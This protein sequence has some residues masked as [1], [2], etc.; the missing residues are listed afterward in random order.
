M[1]VG[2]DTTERTPTIDNPTKY[3]VHVLKET[4]EKNGIDVQGSAIDCDELDSWIHAPQD[5]GYIEV[6]NYY[7]VPLSE[8]VQR[9]MKRSQNMY[10]ETMPRVLSWHETGLG[11]IEGGRKIID[12]VYT[13]FG[14]EPGS[15]AYVDGSGLT[16][17]DYISP[18]ILVKILEGMYKS[19]QKNIWV[20]SLP[21][22]GID[23][24]LRRRM[25]G[26]A[27]EKKVFAKT[28]TI[29]NTRGLSGYTTTASGENIVFSFL[30]NGHLLSSK[31][32]DQITDSVLE[33]IC[34]YK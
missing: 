10:A 16:R 11:S 24:T 18:E 31:D 6:A 28:G 15:W 5:D 1:L 32:T 27:A 22:S 17:Y 9:C 8:V 2:S 23:G 34:S 7:S 26:T 29:S 20:S 25:I 19:D 33:L 14:V 21:I 13:E 12:S 30:V 3:Y 4:L